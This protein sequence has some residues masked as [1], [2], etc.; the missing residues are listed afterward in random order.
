M[1]PTDR[2]SL[3]AAAAAAAVAALAVAVW[4]ALDRLNQRADWVTVQAPAYA[5]VGQP[6]PL[7]ITVKKADVPTWLVVDLHGTDRSR[8]SAGF[9]SSGGRRLVVAPGSYLFEPQVKPREDLAFVVAVVYLSP[10]GDWETRDRSATTDLVRVRS[11]A[12][13]AAGARLGALPAY[14]GDTRVAPS[15]APRDRGAPAWNESDRSAGK[16]AVAGLL[17]AAAAAAAWSARAAGG[18]RRPAWAAMAA[19]LAV[20]AAWELSG[21]GRALTEVVRTIAGTH[22]W[23]YLRKPFQAAVIA[24][25]TAG[26]AGAAVLVGRAG[27]SLGGPLATALIG[28]LLYGVV[29]AV[30]LLSFHATDAIA[31]VSVAGFPLVQVLKAASIAVVLLA[32]VRLPL[33]RRLRDPS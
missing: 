21:A 7:K 33:R 10:T 19:G 12:P 11:G 30:D 3:G 31:G 9:L 26:G 22:D 28:A 13:S 23:Y 17:L 25:L 27:R 18:R 1:K 32:S 6:L 4:L 15:A 20:A 5:A 24:A 14:R 16:T 29:T 8:R 2:R